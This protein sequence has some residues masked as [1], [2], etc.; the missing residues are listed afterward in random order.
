MN[1]TAGPKTQSE[2]LPIDV[3]ME[4]LKNVFANKW[5]LLLISLAIGV[6]AYF[7]SSY[8][9][10]RYASTVTLSIEGA[11]DGKA[12][13]EDGAASSTLNKPFLNT[14]YEILISRDLAERVA[15]NPSATACSEQPDAS[16][17]PSGGNARVFDLMRSVEIT[18]VRNTPL[19]KITARCSTALA[20]K[21]TAELY[22]TE[23]I[24]S[25]YDEFS[26]GKDNVTQWMSG[27]MN[28]LKEKLLQSE[29][30][31]QSYKE[32]ETIYSSQVGSAIEEVE[33]TRLLNA[34]SDEQK[35][36]AG[37]SAVH[38]QIEA[39]G[40]DFQI[41]ELMTITTIREDRIVSQLL[42]ELAGVRARYEGSLELYTNDHPSIN[43]E[44]VQYEQLLRQLQAQV[45]MVSQ[46]IGKQLSAS[47]AAIAN[48][49]R[50]IEMS[51]SKSIV[52]DRKKS[53]LG[54]LEQNVEVNRDLY[55]NFMERVNDLVHAQG[56]MGEQIKIV[57]KAYVPGA[58][59][60]PN[61]K[62]NAGLG[63][64]GAFG[65]LFMFFLIRGLRDSTLK[66]PTDV[67]L[68][69]SALL[70]GYLPHVKS[71]DSTLAYDGYIGNSRS[72]FAEAVR[73]IRTSLSLLNMQKH[74]KVT[75]VTSSVP[76]EGKSTVALNLAAS[77][78]QL[79]KVLLIDADIRRPT[80]VNTLGLRESS[81]GLM[82]VLS[83]EHNVSECIY[84]NQQGKY[85]FMPAGRLSAKFYNNSESPRDPFELLSLKDYAGLIESLKQQYD[86]II[87]D[88]PP[89]CGI[90][91]ARILSA[92]S[93][94]VVYVV[95]A[96]QTN[97]RLIKRG[98]RELQ[99]AN[100]NI[101]GIVLNKV[102]I[103][104]MRQYDYDGYYTSYDP[105]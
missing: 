9:P 94:S 26:T 77:F 37:L 96:F 89:V 63:F 101:A 10:P 34:Y 88:S 79:E 66:A 11:I 59:F 90:S 53:E 105:A 5:K 57:G 42:A 23:F 36:L 39:L 95:A 12:S 85:D 78:G 8:I 48:L 35:K 46:G 3:L 58:P 22:A 62:L 76:N 92:S 84:H 64:T 20:A 31:L 75:V 41:D 103:E 60:S 54:R 30:E 72:V 71:N 50:D 28:E 73:S 40:D 16:G 2:S 91:D 13:W 49:E 47:R 67:E 44:K 38:E 68:K 14:Q 93:T 99:D 21:E 81:G 15:Q 70:L 24:S 33:I 25:K 80:L 82:N 7:L 52:H 18:P 4:G 61:E 6:G 19:F 97:S 74:G 27:R 17:Q 45:R 104:K 102:N 65:L 1:Q 55:R 86:H 32:N 69:L 51:K 87:I 29:S 56:Y 100:A 43:N 83:N 98:L